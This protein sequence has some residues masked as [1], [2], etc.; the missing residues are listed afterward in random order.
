METEKQY[1][2]H[3]CQEAKGPFKCE[4]RG[5][6]SSPDKFPSHCSI[7]RDLLILGA[8]HEQFKTK[9]VY[10]IGFFAISI[11]GYLTLNFLKN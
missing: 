9:F 11:L 4:Y 10:R 8:G 1:T 6:V 3:R 5:C 7:L 2:A